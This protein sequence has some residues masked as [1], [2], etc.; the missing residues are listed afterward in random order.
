MT[1]G[2]F[3]KKFSVF[4]LSLLI[5]ITFFGCKADKTVLQETQISSSLASS[6]ETVHE[7]ATEYTAEGS[8]ENS[9]KN[10]VKADASKTNSSKQTT[11][12]SSGQAEQNDSS[13]EIKQNT[14]TQRAAEKQAQPAKQQAT[15]TS[16]AVTCT[17]TIDCS[18]ILNNM[19]ELKAGHEEFVPSNG[20]IINSCSVTVPNGSTVYDAVVSACKSK[21][22]SVNT[23]NSG[24]GKYISG[25]NNIDEKDCGGESGWIYFVNEKSPSKSCDKYKLSN[26]DSV[27]FRYSC[28]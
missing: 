1:G 22:I 11:S 23:V 14:T 26:G 7:N 4:L 2:F 5:C 17:V 8:A 21:N 12:H 10:T 20:Y 6:A 18:T 3:M 27:V 15:T 9:D 28:S 19:E 13:G 25:F 16:S 24:Y